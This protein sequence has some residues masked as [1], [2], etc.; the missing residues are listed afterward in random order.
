MDKGYSGETLKTYG[1]D[2][3]GDGG[4]RDRNVTSCLPYVIF[5]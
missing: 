2:G 1:S 5:L 4:W 3:D